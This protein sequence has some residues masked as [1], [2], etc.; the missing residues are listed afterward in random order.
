MQH[1]TRTLLAC[2]LVVVATGTV[3]TH[4]HAAAPDH[5]HGLGWASLPTLPA[6]AGLP[7]N[8]RHFVLLGVEFAGIPA[9]E[10]EAPDAS[11]GTRVGPVAEQPVVPDGPVPPAPDAVASPLPTTLVSL[12]P[13]DAP[14]GW[15]SPAAPHCPLTS[16]ARSGVLRT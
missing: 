12:P 16:H 1:P 3:V 5:T 11:T 15:D 4:R 2:W 14:R 6:P 13:T 7:L 9:G 10:G 8:H